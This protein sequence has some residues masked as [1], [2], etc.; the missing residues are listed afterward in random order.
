M[1]KTLNWKHVTKKRHPYELS[2]NRVLV[3]DPIEGEILPR[4]VAKKYDKHNT[5]FMQDDFDMDLMAEGRA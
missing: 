3:G 2:D 5:P 1:R 4:K